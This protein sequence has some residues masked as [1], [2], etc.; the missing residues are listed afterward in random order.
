M[1]NANEFYRLVEVLVLAQQQDSG[2]TYSDLANAILKSFVV[3]PRDELPEVTRVQSGTFEYV[4]TQGPGG[5]SYGLTPGDTPSADDPA[6]LVAIVEWF[7]SQGLP[8][9]GES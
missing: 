5:W 4:R 7:R 1:S 3:I 8:L 2:L 9:H 6:H